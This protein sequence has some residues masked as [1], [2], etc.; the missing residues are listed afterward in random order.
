MGGRVG[1]EMEEERGGVLG[2]GVEAAL[3]PCHCGTLAEVVWA[4]P[5]ADRKLACAGSNVQ[6]VSL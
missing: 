5:S 4:S 3:R 1:E 2:A 6:I